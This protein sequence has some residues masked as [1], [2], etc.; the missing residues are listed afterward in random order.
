MARRQGVPRAL[1]AAGA[2]RRIVH[3]PGLQLAAGRWRAC[4][5][6]RRHTDRATATAG[7][8]KTRPGLAICS[9]VC[10]PP[11]AEYGRPALL[12]QPGCPATPVPCPPV[13]SDLLLPAWLQ[14]RC[15]AMAG[16]TP[17]DLAGLTMQFR[18]LVN[19]PGSHGYAKARTNYH[20][21]AQQALEPSFIFE[22]MLVEEEE[23]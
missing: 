1:D 6:A 19:F 13:R 2:A 7:R 16:P 12:P 20:F 22:C 18:G 17:Q 5:V 11:R 9:S 15:E 23:R 4:T 8:G 14:G 10:V 21:A 3:G